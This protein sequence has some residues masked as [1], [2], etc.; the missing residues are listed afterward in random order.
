[1]NRFPKLKLIISLMFF[2]ALG[3]CTAPND[4][5]VNPDTKY[6]LSNAFPSLRHVDSTVPYNDEE[7]KKFDLALENLV[8]FGNDINAQILGT[9]K[10]LS[11]DMVRKIDGESY[12]V[13]PPEYV[14]KEA[15]KI[16][17]KNGSL[18]RGRL[19]EY[20]LN[21]IQK[22]K[23]PP[24]EL[25]KRVELSAF[26]EHMQESGIFKKR[27]IRPYSRSVLANISRKG[28]DYS[29]KAFAEM[30]SKD[31]LGT[32]AA[33]VAVATGHPAALQLVEDMM[34]QL[35]NKNPKPTA[36]SLETTNRL[37]ELS[38]ALYFGGEAS[39]KHLTPL[40]EFMERKVQFWAFPFHTMVNVTPK[41]MCRILKLMGNPETNAGK[42]F[43]YCDAKDT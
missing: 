26:N 39:R 8:I 42:H 1:M 18:S 24:T 22:M 23:P 3:Y 6:K 2:Y 12:W 21:L 38:Y 28:A 13:L 7:K 36:I 34:W 11:R 37:Y 35:L 27:D 32:G 31:S 9:L 15:T 29:E 14:Y 17:I 5:P 41:R 16:L 25:I 40:Y 33:Q 19:T 30:S 20:G 43:E 10:F 4:P